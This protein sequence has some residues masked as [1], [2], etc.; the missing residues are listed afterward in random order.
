MRVGLSV[1]I[2]PVQPAGRGHAAVS[3]GEQHDWVAIH[4][5][6]QALRVGGHPACSCFVSTQVTGLDVL[7]DSTPRWSRQPGSRMT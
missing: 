5:P 4:A 1:V 2:Q 6:R 7:L 3:T